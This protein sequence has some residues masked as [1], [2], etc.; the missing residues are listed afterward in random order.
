MFK[1]ILVLN[2]LLC[3]LIH[4]DLLDFTSFT[5]FY[6]S[7]LNL[8]EFVDFSSDFPLSVSVGFIAGWEDFD[9]SFLVDASNRL[10][11]SCKESR[12]VGGA[13]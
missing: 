1:K 13:N 10:R 11:D 12:M 4:P 5:E 8:P 6:I 7:F 9:L 3:G 2:W